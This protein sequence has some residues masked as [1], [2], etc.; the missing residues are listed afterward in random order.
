MI[1]GRRAPRH[2]P[3][4]PERAT[5]VAKAGRDARRELRERLAAAN[6]ARIEERRGLPDGWLF[7]RM[8]RAKPADVLITKRAPYTGKGSEGGMTFMSPLSAR[9]ARRTAR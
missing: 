9:A 2:A 6:G 1:V 5:K 7:E 8:D 4:P 3:A